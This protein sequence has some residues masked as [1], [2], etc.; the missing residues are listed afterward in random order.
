MMSLWSLFTPR[1]RMRCFA[2]LDAKGNCRALREAREQP[3]GN[4]WIE[5]CELRQHWLGRPLPAHAVLAPDQPRLC[6][7][8]LLAA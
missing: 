3:R 6:E 1:A 4:G 2:L 8:S 7:K 5:V